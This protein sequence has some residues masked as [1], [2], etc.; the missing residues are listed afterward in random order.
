M[1]RSF[2][3]ASVSLCYFALYISSENSRLQSSGRELVYYD[4]MEE[5]FCIQRVLQ[6]TIILQRKLFRAGA[7]IKTG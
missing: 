4:S 1:Q 2:L 7:F 3:L 5:L 6:G